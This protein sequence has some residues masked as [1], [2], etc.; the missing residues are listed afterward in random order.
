MMSLICVLKISCAR[1]TS[2]HLLNT[3]HFFGLQSDS[4]SN[5][6][7]V[8][9]DREFLLWSQSRFITVIIIL[10]IIF[11]FSMQVWNKPLL[12]DFIISMTL[13][14]FSN[15]I[16]TKIGDLSVL[17]N[18]DGWIRQIVTYLPDNQGFSKRAGSHAWISFIF[19]PENVFFGP[20]KWPHN[21]FIF[22]FRGYK[23][24]FW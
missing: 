6:W 10:I 19:S 4:K 8:T 9:T 17:P 2:D 12:P 5:K 16:C 15:I 13:I 14:Q 20:K 1:E 24:C 7:P 22:Q 21:M 3:T 18:P 11:C 23:T